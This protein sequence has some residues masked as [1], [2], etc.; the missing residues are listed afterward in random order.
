MR[1]IFISYA[2]VDSAHADQIAAIL[3]RL[4]LPFFRDVKDIEWGKD[5]DNEVTIGLTDCS[6]VL[7]VISPG[8]LKSQWVP[9][10]LG[11]ARGL[12]KRI[13]PFLTSPA[14]DP[15]GYLGKLHY[16]SDIPA[17]ESFLSST[18]GRKSIE[19]TNAG[20]DPQLEAEYLSW[21]E[22]QNEKRTDD[23]IRFDG[24]EFHVDRE[25]LEADFF[26]LKR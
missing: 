9:Y 14:L 13:L 2:R 4:S 11:F 10:E 17:V 23:E 16:F 24:L 1:P 18:A 25:V 6:A 12:R 15:P 19:K 26:P 3:D 20:P 5:V 22:S 8:S 21:W 7:V